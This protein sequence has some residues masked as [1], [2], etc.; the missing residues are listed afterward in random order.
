MQR[1]LVKEGDAVE[2]GTPIV[3]IEN[4]WAVMQLK[5]KGIVKKILFDSGATVRIGDPVAIIGADGEAAPLGQ[6]ETL[7][8]LKNK[9]NKH[10]TIVDE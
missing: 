5:A 4:Y 3:T 2:H 7:E 8:I 1:Y 9:R 6:D 10:K